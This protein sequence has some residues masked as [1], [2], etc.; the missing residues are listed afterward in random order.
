MDQFLPRIV[1]DEPKNMRISILNSLFVGGASN[2]ARRLHEGLRLIGADST[3]FNFNH[4][5]ASAGIKKCRTERRTTTQRLKLRVERL[6][7]KMTGGL[8]SRVST[9]RLKPENEL[10]SNCVSGSSERMDYEELLDCDVLNLHWISLKIDFPPLIEDVCRKRPLVWTLHDMRPFTG[11]CHY[12]DSCGK[13]RSR[14]GNCPQLVSPGK[15]DASRWNFR[16]QENALRQVP[17]ENLRIVAPSKWLTDSAKNSELL[18]TFECSHIPYGVCTDTFRPVDNKIAR[19]LLGLKPDRFV[20]LFVAS[21]MQNYRKGFDLLVDAVRKLKD[22]EDNL[23]LLSVG[24]GGVPKICGEVPHIHLG[25]IESDLLLA[26]IYSA[27]DVFVIPSRQDNLPNTVLE[28][29]ACGTPVVGFRV[30][31]VPDVVREGETGWLA[32]EV[33][34]NALYHSLR[35]SIQDLKNSKVSFVNSCRKVA[36]QEFGIRVQAHKYIEVYKDLISK[37]KRE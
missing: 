28:S 13:Y 31:G 10:F 15:N 21:S 9:F 3:F 32:S 36:L 29:I 22:R 6:L 2:S 26:Q 1:P 34:A 11:G 5:D 37:F 12:D 14:C 7:C 35:Q 24:S 19:E 30:G 23:L 20:L 8:Y 16:R 25:A 17:K 27:A 18:G 4:E 33:N